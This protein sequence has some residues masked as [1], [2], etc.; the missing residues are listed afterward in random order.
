MSVSTKGDKHELKGYQGNSLK[1]NG[2]V[3]APVKY[4]NEDQILPIVVVEGNRPALLGRN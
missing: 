1:V 2:V 3:W 4:E